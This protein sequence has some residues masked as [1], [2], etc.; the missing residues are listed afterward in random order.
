MT[1]K[2]LVISIG[3]A[4]AA[5]FVFDWIYH[6]MLLK[7][8]YEGTA[9][10]WRPEAEMKSFCAWMA[11]GQEV[12]AIAYVLL[13]RKGYENKG[14]SEGVRFG[15]YMGGFMAGPS[16]GMYA[17]MP[18]PLALALAWVVGGFLQAIA[19]GVALSFTARP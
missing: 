19:V 10:L 6:G 17:Y 12:L 16:L 14:V 3:A 13:F 5:V 8:M 11:A 1:T 4:F 7:G 2:K 18:I 15:L 9:Q